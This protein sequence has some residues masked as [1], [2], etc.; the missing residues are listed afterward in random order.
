MGAN[1]QVPR[2]GLCCKFA[3]PH[4]LQNVEL[5]SSIKVFTTLLASLQFDLH[6]GENAISS[7]GRGPNLAIYMHRS[8][9][10]YMYIKHGAEYVWGI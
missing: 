3:R 9:Y 8:M 6:A 2:D 7:Q 10:I 5:P 4:E 1:E